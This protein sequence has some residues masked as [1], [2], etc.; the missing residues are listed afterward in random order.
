M[1]LQTVC[2]FH[3][4][5]LTRARRARIALRVLSASAAKTVSSCCAGSITY[6]LYNRPII[7]CLVEGVKAYVLRGHSHSQ[8]CM[9]FAR[10][11]VLDFGCR[12]TAERSG[13]A[14]CMKLLVGA[15]LLACLFSLHAE[16]GIVSGRVVDE[17]RKPVP[18]I[19]IIV[20]LASAPQ[21]LDSESEAISIQ[22]DNSR[23]GL[24]RVLTN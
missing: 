6:R 19:R 9:L 15:T 17:T 5:S 16:E 4:G 3:H 18:G 1:S 24:L 10:H 23:F 14:L 21:S 22:A 2:E 7:Y 12:S 13:V 20:A 11:E 8:R